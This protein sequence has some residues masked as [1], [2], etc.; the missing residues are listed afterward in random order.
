[1]KAIIEA[2]G[3]NK[4]YEMSKNV[5]NHVLKDID[6]VI[7]EGEFVSVMGP[8]GSGKSTLLYNISTMDKMTRGSVTFDD[9]VIEGADEK[10]LASVRLKHMGFVFQQSH[11]LK[12]LNVLDNIVL[13]G[14]ASGQKSKKAI[15]LRGLNLL[16]ELGIE[17]IAHHKITEVSGGQLQRASI[18]RALINEPKVLFGDEPTGA[19]NSKASQEVMEIFKAINDQGT[20]V[21]MVTHDAKVAARSERVLFMAD[22][23]LIDELIL[24]K[25]K[26]EDHL[27]ER[28]VKLNNWLQEQGF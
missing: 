21:M 8:S 15:K 11:L 20:T 23:V 1:M 3:L 27:P 22:G 14:F 16:K 5:K 17:D 7:H 19:L 6:L 9:M 10:S 24:G 2:R 26:S 13:P 18:A 4:V 25:Y 28:E 12:D